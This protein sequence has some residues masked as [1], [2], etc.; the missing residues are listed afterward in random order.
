M[1]TQQDASFT[2][3]GLLL[4]SLP[5]TGQDLGGKTGKSEPRHCPGT[6]RATAEDNRYTEVQARMRVRRAPARV[7]QN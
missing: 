1:L 5:Q 4:A 7:T 6:N 3:I 2:V